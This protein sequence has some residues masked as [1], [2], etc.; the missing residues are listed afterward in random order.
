MNIVKNGLVIR[1]KNQNEWVWVEVPSKV[2]K[3]ATNET[4]YE[5]IETDLKEYV[6][7]I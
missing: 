5:K 6:K 7:R 2:F 1:D 4:E 3:T